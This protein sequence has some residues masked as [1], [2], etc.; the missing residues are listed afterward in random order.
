MSDGN[1]TFLVDGKTLNVS[2]LA[3][4]PSADKIGAAASFRVLSFEPVITKIC[5]R[6]GCRA[7]RAKIDNMISTM[8][9]LISKEK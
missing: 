7:D 8:K 5:N 6:S 3:E 1:F 2:S 9:S 4:L